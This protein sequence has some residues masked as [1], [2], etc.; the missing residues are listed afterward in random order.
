LPIIKKLIPIPE[1]IAS[2]NDRFYQVFSPVKVRFAGP[3]KGPVRDL[4]QPLKSI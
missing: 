1:K 4:F 3:E 2:K